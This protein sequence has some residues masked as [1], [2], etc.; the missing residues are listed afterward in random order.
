MLFE[1]S[2]EMSCGVGHGVH[3]PKSRC[4][5]HN[6]DIPAGD[7]VEKSHRLIEWIGLSSLNDEELAALYWAIRHEIQDRADKKPGRDSVP[8]GARDEHS[9]DRT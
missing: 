4:L 8:L 1:A 5:C 9:G 2:E 3:E 7:E 6:L